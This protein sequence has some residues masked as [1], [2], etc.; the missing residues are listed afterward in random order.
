MIERRRYG[1][2]E[3][4]IYQSAFATC[5]A[6]DVTFV[7]CYDILAGILTARCILGSETTELSHHSMIDAHSL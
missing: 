2:Y 7:D 3:W 1:R 4:N 5:F 6:N